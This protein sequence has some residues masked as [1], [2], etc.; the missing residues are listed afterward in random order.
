MSTITDEITRIKG[1]ADTIKSCF[2]EIKNANGATG[3]G[4]FS[5]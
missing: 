2:G 1:A 3:G 4:I 5:R